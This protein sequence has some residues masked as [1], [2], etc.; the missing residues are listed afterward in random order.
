M[1]DCTYGCQEEKDEAIEQEEGSYGILHLV[2]HTGSPQVK[3]YIPNSVTSFPN[4]SHQIT[5]EKLNIR[6][7]PTFTF[8]FFTTDRSIFKQFLHGEFSTESKHS[9]LNQKYNMS[10]SLLCY[11]VIHALDP[12]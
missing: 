1:L 2:N 6:F 11:I 4:I 8:H 10:D 3:S 12:I 7:I 9:L 5:R